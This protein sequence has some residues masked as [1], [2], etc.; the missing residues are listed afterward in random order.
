MNTKTSSSESA[1]IKL[2]QQSLQDKNPIGGLSK[3]GS[4]GTYSTGLGRPS[5]FFMQPQEVKGG[6]IRAEVTQLA[7]EGGVPPRMVGQLTSSMTYLDQIKSW[8]SQ[9][10][11]VQ[12]TRLYTINEVISLARLEG[13]MGRRAS[14]QLVGNALTACGFVPKRDWTA[15]G[16]NKRYWQ[17]S[18]K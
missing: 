3:S 9:L 13:R 15:A 12:L 8:C 10:S 4:F 17:W 2:F 5:S 16:R 14:V 11:K 6:Y 18:Q 7:Q 1:E